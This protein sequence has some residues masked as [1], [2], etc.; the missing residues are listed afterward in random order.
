MSAR[1][2]LDSQDHAKET[3]RLRHRKG[4]KTN[5]WELRLKVSRRR[6]RRKAGLPEPSY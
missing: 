3:G 6:A 5:R 1:L 2:W 4:R